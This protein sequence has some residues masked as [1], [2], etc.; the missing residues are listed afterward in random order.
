[1]QPIGLEA[2]RTHWAPRDVATLCFVVRDGEILLIRKKRGL[3]AGKV[4][5]P[6]GR[7][8]AGETPEACAVREVEEE[9][10]TTPQ[11]LSHRGELRFQFADGYSLHCHVF[12][13]DGCDRAPRETD[14]AAPLWTPVEAIP[15]GEMWADDALWL[16]KMLAGWRFEGDFLFDGDVMGAHALRWFDPAEALWP[17][18]RPWCPNFEVFEHAPHFTVAH[19]RAHRAVD[20]PEVGFIKNFYLRD[21]KG[22]PYLVT[23]REDRA[24]SLK[25]LA[26]HLGVGSLT[27]ASATRLR[28]DLGV[29]AGSVTPLAALND[30]AGRVKLVFDL[31]LLVYRDIAC[32]PLTNDRTVLVPSE[33]LFGFL[34][35]TGHIPQVVDMRGMGPEAEGAGSTG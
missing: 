6:G 22:N 5:G 19:A 34:A 14:E 28:E 3:G 30:R 29:E 16:P 23:V 11:G 18:L 8:E 17:L 35:Q 13:A 33:N 26:R 15:Y 24:L 20:D 12:R 27:F 7:L 21:R 10:G 4:N 31:E 25:A 32:H 9:L 1:M 2:L